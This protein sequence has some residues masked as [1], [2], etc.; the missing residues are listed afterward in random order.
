MLTPYPALLRPARLSYVH[1]TQIE[2]GMQ[3]VEKLADG[4]LDIGVLGSAPTAIALSRPHELP[5]EVISVQLENWEADS[6]VVR[7]KIRSPQVFAIPR[8]HNTECPTT[9]VSIVAIPDSGATKLCFAFVKNKQP[10]SLISL[11]S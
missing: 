11:I 7:S 3:G 5:V 9:I 10:S 8:V 1:G 2:S 6:L 4:T